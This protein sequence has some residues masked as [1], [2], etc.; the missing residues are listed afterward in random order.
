MIESYGIDIHFAQG[1]AHVDDLCF[2][3]IFKLIKHG[4]IG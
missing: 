4:D 1:F 2:D 3:E